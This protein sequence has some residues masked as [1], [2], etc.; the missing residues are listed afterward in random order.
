MTVLLLYFPQDFSLSG[1]YSVIS[2]D[3]VSMSVGSERDKNGEW[4]RLDSEELNSL[5]RLLNIVRVFE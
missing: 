1:N 2:T 5:Y 3:Q 4:A